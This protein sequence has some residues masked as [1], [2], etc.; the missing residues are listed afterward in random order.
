MVCLGVGVGGRHKIRRMLWCLAEAARNA[1]RRYLKNAESVSIIQDG[2]RSKL[3]I[4]FRACDHTL[5]PRQG[6]LW[7]THLHNVQAHHLREGTLQGLRNFCTEF[8]KAP[9]SKPNSPQPQFDKVLFKRLV[10]TI[11]CFTSD[12]AADEQ[13]AG[14]LLKSTNEVPTVRDNFPALANLKVIARDRAHAA[15]RITKRPWAAD[16]ELNRVMQQCVL[17]KK[18]VTNL[19]QYSHVFSNWFAQNTQ[20]VSY[21]VTDSARVKDLAL[22]KQ[23][24]DSM[25]KP[26]SRL[27]LLHEA[28]L[29]TA[30]QIADT[31][32]RA[33]EG[34][35]AR[36][37]L[38][39]CS[40]EVLVTLALLADAADESLAH[41][42]MLDRDHVDNAELQEMNSDFLCRITYLFGPQEGCWQSGH[43]RFLLERLK[44]TIVVFVGGRAVS[45]G[46]PNCISEATKRSHC[47]A[48]RLGAATLAHHTSQTKHY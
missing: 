25:S 4:R 5:R 45:I 15:R 47:V 23:R 1:D 42:R 16:A 46:G 41:I 38:E 17:S 14:E 43:T 31:R 44:K 24:F 35:I 10:Q 40:E 3:L 30:Q 34:R 27:V 20:K 28:V 37:F 18:S 32:P 7:Q 22:A 12:A 8:A 33:E 13:L 29:L 48:Q 9:E 36:E 26:T 21:K 11:E 6:I 39:M 2:R 19:I